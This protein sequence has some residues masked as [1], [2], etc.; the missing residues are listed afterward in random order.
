MVAARYLAAIG[1]VAASLGLRFMLS[2]YFGPNVPYLQFFPA[3]LVA[4]WYGGF[5]PGV[6]ATA[7]SAFAALYWFIAPQGAITIATIADAVTLTL[8]A[9]IG[10][11]IA[12]LNGRLRAARDLARHEAQLATSRAERL[13]AVINTTVDGIIVIDTHGIVEAF[14][15]G[16]ERLFGYAAADVIG[17]NVKLLMPPPFRGE[18]DGYLDRYLRTGRP[19]IIGQ[20]REV[21]G[22]RADG[23]TFPLHL[24]VGEMMVDGERKFTGMLHDVSARVTLEQQ[25]RA[26]EEKWRSIIHSA[27]DGIIVIN[28]RGEIEAF[29]PAAT[30]L[31]GYAESEVVGR[32]VNMLMPSPYHEEHDSY[33]ATYLRTGEAKIIGMGREVTGLRKDG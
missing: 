20:G 6:L 23:S 32:N 17:Q 29:N 24:S 14:N 7:L 22:R 10:I 31:F 25:L 11:A 16:A 13:A 4:S 12:W 8:F 27:V 21:M 5:G 18:H 26:S 19:A 1:C 30:R 15:P 9:V 33:L 28:A 2:D 3:I